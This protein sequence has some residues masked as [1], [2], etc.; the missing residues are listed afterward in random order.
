LF[1][2][3]PVRNKEFPAAAELEHWLCRQK[4]E[5]SPVS[6]A[7]VADK[8]LDTVRALAAGFP[9]KVVAQEKKARV[10]GRIPTQKLESL[11]IPARAVLVRE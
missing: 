5:L 2:V 4:A 3:N 6:A 1:P 7:L 8:V 11:L 9:V 10:E